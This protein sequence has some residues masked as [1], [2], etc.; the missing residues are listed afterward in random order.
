MPETTLNDR[1]LYSINIGE[2]WTNE[3]EI[4]YSEH[5][6][7]DIVINLISKLR[8][9]I[10]VKGECNFRIQLF[11]SGNKEDKDYYN[12][13]MNLFLENTNDLKKIFELDFFFD[14]EGNCFSYHNYIEVS[15]NDENFD[16]WFTLFLRKFKQNIGKIHDF[17][18]YQLLK[19]FNKNQSEFST[20]LKLCFRQ[21]SEIIPS[22]VIQTSQEW[23]DK[24][25]DEHAVKNRKNNQGIKSNF[26][27]KLSFKL[28]DVLDFNDY[29]EKKAIVLPE[30]IQELRQEFIDETT[31]IQQLKDILSGIEINPKNRINWIGSFKEL[32]MFVSII[33]SDLRKIEPIKNGIWETTC[34][35]F[36]KNGKEIEV[37]Q[38]SKANGDNGKRTKLYSILEKL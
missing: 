4:F 2:I 16:Y 21:Y 3:R 23:L 24:K 28:K 17:L 12:R 7:E 5:K 27:T 14:S 38:L 10:K 13:Q 15:K 1:N 32:N 6:D 19:N 33:N 18:E 9:I 35:C 37:H 25:T 20:F 22:K 8:D 11:D 31:K 34:C 26:V 30:I 36:T 29:F